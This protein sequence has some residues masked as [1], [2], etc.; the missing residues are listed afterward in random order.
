LNAAA[1]ANYP[2]SDRKNGHHYQEQIAL[3]GAVLPQRP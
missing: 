2:L 3:N 1:S